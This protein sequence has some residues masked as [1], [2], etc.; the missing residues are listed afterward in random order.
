MKRILFVIFTIYC[1]LPK[2]SPA[3]E[4][5]KD[6]IKET[7]VILKGR[8]VEVSPSDDSV[9][10]KIYV[11]AF[12]GKLSIDS[13]RPVINLVLRE[14]SGDP[15]HHS[16]KLLNMSADE[17]VMLFLQH[18]DFTGWSLVPGEYSLLKIGRLGLKDYA[19]TF[20]GDRNILTDF[21]SL[22]VIYENIRTIK[23][24]PILT[25]SFN[26]YSEFS[27]IAGIKL[28][29]PQRVDNYRSRVPASVDQNDPEKKSGK[30]EVE[31]LIPH[32]S[33]FFLSLLCFFHHI[34]VR[35]SR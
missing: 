32:L 16:K 7:D 24:S 13:H 33:L 28:N 21:V 20:S 10:L 31:T 15:F 6:L 23:N 12:H 29:S 35:R 8:I 14:Q 1:L 18:R 3:A 19:Y 27:L 5:I 30:I 34:F 2:I 22:E 4:T 9:E 17:N 11:D 26:G 25:K